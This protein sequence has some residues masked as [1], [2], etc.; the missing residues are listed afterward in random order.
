MPL[1]LRNR[2][3]LDVSQVG[4]FNAYQLIAS[5][6]NFSMSGALPIPISEIESY[7]NLYKIHDVEIIE[8]LHE[9]ISF[10]DGVYLEHVGKEQKKTKK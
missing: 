5:S 10:L 3:E 2:P 6:R 7:C 8:V 4:Y 9:R 1:A